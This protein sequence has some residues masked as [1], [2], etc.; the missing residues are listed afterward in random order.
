MGM[1]PQHITVYV[2]LIFGSHECIYSKKQNKMLKEKKTTFSTKKGS[3]WFPSNIIWK[4][5][6]KDENV[7]V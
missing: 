2:A 7:L 4:T 5:P 1:R 3:S 6:Q